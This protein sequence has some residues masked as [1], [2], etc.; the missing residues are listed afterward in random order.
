MNHLFN[1]PEAFIER[2]YNQLK[3]LQ[4]GSHIALSGGSS[5]S[6]ISPLTAAGFDWSQYR[7]S[8]VDERCVGSDHEHSNYTYV[9]SRLPEKAFLEPFYT[10]DSTVDIDRHAHFLEKYPIDVALLG[11]G[12]DGHTASLFPDSNTSKEAAVAH[13]TTDTFAVHD[14]LTLTYSA[15][16]KIPQKYFLLFGDTK[17][18]IMQQMKSNETLPASRVYSTGADVFYAP[19]RPT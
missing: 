7:L 8:L 17:K 15:L 6:V 9:A 16:E 19:K 18:Q 2:L 1:T 5:A 11:I 4:K 13:T 3:T 14:R 10:G 12:P